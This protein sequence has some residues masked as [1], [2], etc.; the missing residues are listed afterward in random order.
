MSFDGAEVSEL[1]GL[2]ILNK[3]NKIVHADSQSH[4][5]D[6]GLHDNQRANG[7]IRK[8][9]FKFFQDLDFDITVDMNR[10]MIQYLDMEF[11]LSAS[12]VSHIQNQT[13]C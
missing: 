9:F 3:I 10:K 13:W 2:F 5:R 8:M 6:D 11:T 1:M 12:T 7:K 4:Y